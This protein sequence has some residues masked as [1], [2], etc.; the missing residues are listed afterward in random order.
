MAVARVKAAAKVGAM[1]AAVVDA[2]VPTAVGRVRVAVMVVVVVAKAVRWKAANRAPKVVSKVVRKADPKDEV[3]VAGVKAVESPVARAAAKRAGSRA[4]TFAAKAATNPAVKAVEKAVERAVG[5]KVAATTAA[6]PPQWTAPRLP[7]WRTA[8]RSLPATNHPKALTPNAGV[9]VDAVVKTAV[10]RP[11]AP[12]AWHQSLLP[13]PH[14]RCRT[15]PRAPTP[16]AKARWS[17][18]P[19]VPHGRR[20]SAAAAT[21]T[22]GIAASADRAMPPGHLRALKTRPCRPNCPRAK[23][24]LPPHRPWHRCTTSRPMK[25]PR[26]AISACPW[27]LRRRLL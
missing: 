17:R 27:K 15:R 16:T 2:A 10:A 26:A 5:A 13:M 1:A 24:R 6:T 19:T 21:A 9:A 25:H 14:R 23:W 18:V 22:A 4:Q 3:T 7:N 12:K 8:C 11:T 20:V